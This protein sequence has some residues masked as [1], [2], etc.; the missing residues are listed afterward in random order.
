MSAMR[1]AILRW[2]GAPPE[3]GEFD[4]P[5][6]GDGQEVVEVLAAG[7]NPV[8]IRMASGTFYGGTPPLPSVVGREGVGRTPDG[9]LVYFD[10][11]IPPYGAFAERALIARDS[12]I[13]LPAELDPA[14]AVSFGIAGLAAWLAL[15]WRAGLREGENVL[16]LGASG[17]VG[18]VAV[19]GARLLGAG[20][21]AAAARSPEGL[22]RARDLGAD[23]VVSLTLREDDL[24][25][26]LREAAGGDGFDVVI[27]PVWG[28]PAAAALQACRVRGRLVQIGESAGPHSTLASATIRGKL[29]AVLG[30]T[31]F[32]APPDVKRAAYERMVEHGARGELAVEVERVP[33]EQVADAWQRQQRSPHHKLVI[34]P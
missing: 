5:Q 1:A 13:P 9:R 24:V 18:Q 7:L 27:D 16:V 4:E 6:A 25:D 11:P 8:D 3:P 33:L 19:Q 31:N 17:V 32:M 15:D 29:L 28:D 2:Y 12:A 20:R 30:H 14:L 22:D 23:A 10:G 21:V 26:A 34:V